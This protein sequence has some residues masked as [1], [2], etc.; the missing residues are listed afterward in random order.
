MMKTGHATIEHSAVGDIPA[1]ILVA[2]NYRA[3]ICPGMGANCFLLEHEGASLLRRPP[4]F[5]VFRENPN[6]FGLPLLFPPNRIRGGKFTFQ[7]RSY[8]LPVNEAGRGHHIHGF[9][10]SAPF[11]PFGAQVDDDSCRLSFAYEA[12][13]DAPYS[14]F[15]H[16]FRIVLGYSLDAREGLAQRLEVENRS[17]SEMPLGLGFHSAFNCPFLPETSAGDYRLRLG[18]S[19]EILLDPAS[20]IPTGGVLRESELISTLNGEGIPPQGGA[21]SNHF[22]GAEELPREARLVHVPSGRSIAYRVDSLFAFW[23][24]WNQGGD[25]NF[26][27]AEPQTW[28]IDAP[29]SILPPEE[30]GF[31]ALAP[32][33]SIAL[34]ST[35]RATAAREEQA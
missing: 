2:G 8:S 29:N 32:G 12:T 30:S 26:V 3:A 10:S 28:M 24:L 16:A 35:I 11:A 7:G 20:I 5:A 19:R 34:T 4:S 25:K 13:K 23:T 1:I 27:C 15:P 31:R 9:L 17:D 6:V 14:T 18:V 21:L 22:R 33:Q